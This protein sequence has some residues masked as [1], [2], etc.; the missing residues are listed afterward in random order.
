MFQD[1]PIDFVRKFGIVYVGLIGL[2]I[3]DNNPLLAIYS[4]YKLL[5][6]GGYLQWDEM[7]DALSFVTSVDPTIKTEAVEAMRQYMHTPK[8][9][10]KG[11]H[12]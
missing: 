3:K 8:G 1:I 6:P 11:L 2:V 7:D 5:K 4:L 9:D 12:E 10:V